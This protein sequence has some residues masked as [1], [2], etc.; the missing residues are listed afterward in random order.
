M[1]RKNIIKQL[2]YLHNAKIMIK[3][4]NYVFLAI[5]ASIATT[6]ATVGISIITN[7]LNIHIH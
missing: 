1:L 2:R 6:V 4:C 3:A 7:K 5:A